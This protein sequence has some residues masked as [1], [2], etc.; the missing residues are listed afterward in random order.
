M[1]LYSRQPYQ[2]NKTCFGRLIAQRVNLMHFDG[3]VCHIVL[4]LILQNNM[5]LKPSTHL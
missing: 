1:E 2:Q 3:L 4:R 5:I